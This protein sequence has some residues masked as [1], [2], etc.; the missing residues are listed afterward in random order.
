[1]NDQESI[2]PA[3][4]HVFLDG[5]KSRGYE[6]GFAWRV[7][8]QFIKGFRTLHFVGPCITVFGSARFKEDHPYYVQARE[9]G[10]RIAQLGFT[11][12]TGGGPGI[13]E[14]ANRGAFENG[15]QSIGC[16]IQLPFEQH[17]NPY[18]HKSVTFEHFFIRKVLL[19][20]Y[21]YAFII[22]PGGFGTMDEFFETL[23]L[24]QTKTIT[25]FPIVLF[26]KEYY[27][28]LLVAIEDMAEKGTISKEDMDLVLITD[29]YDEAMSHIRHYITSNYK[30]KPRKRKWIFLEKR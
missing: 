2:I 4:E 15:G 27:K 17:E 24:V 6:L 5:P 18:L 22:M 21:S 16:N 26:G 28:D 29:D 23:T 1:M 25:Q 14:A 30:V 11:T 7:F 9:F 10:K 12:M 3:K 20:K 19:I 13:M 8:K